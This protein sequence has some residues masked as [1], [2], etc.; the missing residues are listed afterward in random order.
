MALVTY[1]AD[2]ARAGLQVLS[3]PDRHGEAFEGVII[4]VGLTME[5]KYEHQ[6][7]PVTLDLNGR[8]STEFDTS[9]DIILCRN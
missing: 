2:L 1:T 9:L 5:V 6:E 4:A 3:R 7:H 8:Y